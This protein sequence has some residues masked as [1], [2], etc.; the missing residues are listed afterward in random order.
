[1]PAPE[2]AATEYVVV[3][4]DTLGKIAKKNGVTLKAIEAANPGSC[5]NQT[6]NRTKTF[7]S[8]C[9]WQR[10]R[11]YGALTASPA[12]DGGEEIYRSNPATP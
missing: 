1:M 5:S 6:E 2:A 12:T 10:D 9:V 11:A 7:N 8:G 3:K 4:G